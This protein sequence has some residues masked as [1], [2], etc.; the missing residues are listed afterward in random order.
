MD[1]VTVQFALAVPWSLPAVLLAGATFAAL[2]LKV[3]ILWVVLA[4]G[5]L[6]VFLL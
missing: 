1:R 2:R 5:A 4:G 6:S 3:D